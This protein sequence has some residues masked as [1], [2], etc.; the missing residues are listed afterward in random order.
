MY[1]PERSNELLGS[2]NLKEKLYRRNGN[3]RM[4]SV[5]QVRLSNEILTLR[6]Q[7]A[8]IFVFYFF[9]KYEKQIA[10]TVLSRIL[11]AI[12]QLLGNAKII[13]NESRFRRMLDVQLGTPAGLGFF[14]SE[15]S[16]NFYFYL[17]MKILNLV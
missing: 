12:L 11:S 1:Q 3:M 9:F 7:A 5:K 13:V 2:R 10:V 14:N 8:S 16:Q 15:N 4:G 6:L 17:N